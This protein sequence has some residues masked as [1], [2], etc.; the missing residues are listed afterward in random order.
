MKTCEK[1]AFFDPL[2]QL[3]LLYLASAKYD[4]HEH[5]VDQVKNVDQKL[6]KQLLEESK[7]ALLACYEIADE[8][9]EF[10]SKY[11]TGTKKFRP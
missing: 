3:N 2:D 9:M 11:L 5:L 10:A 4:N 6:P 1:L 8:G 7:N